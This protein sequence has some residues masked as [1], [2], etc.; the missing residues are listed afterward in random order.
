MGIILRAE[1]INMSTVYS[2][3]LTLAAR[4]EHVIDYLLTFL[5]IKI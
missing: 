2:E 3:Q 4:K 5:V 1:A